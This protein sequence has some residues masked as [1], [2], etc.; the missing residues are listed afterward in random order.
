MRVWGVSGAPCASTNYCAPPTAAKFTLKFQAK[1]PVRLSEVLTIN[2]LH[3]PAEAY[4][5]SERAIEIQGVR[6]EFET[7]QHSNTTF[8]NVPNPFTRTTRLQFQ[9]AHASAVEFRVLDLQGRLLKTF[10][11]YFPPGSR[12]L[13]ID[14]GDL[15]HTGLLF[16]EMRAAGQPPQVVQMI[17][18]Q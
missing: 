7:G 1:K 13:E 17:K 9:V 16:C 2:S 6:L 5:L 18:S 10:G 15:P 8:K 12:E 4:L 14:L 11:G 3:T